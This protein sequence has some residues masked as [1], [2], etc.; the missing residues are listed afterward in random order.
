MSGFHF[1]VCLTSTETYV[2]S[3]IRN[4]MLLKILLESGATFNWLSKDPKQQ[5][6]IRAK[7]FTIDSW[8][9]LKAN[10]M[11]C[12]K[13]RVT[14]SLLFLVVNLIC[15]GSA[16]F[17]DQSGRSWVKGKESWIAFD[18]QLKFGCRLYSFVLSFSKL[19]L[20]P[21][22]WSSHWFTKR[23]ARGNWNRNLW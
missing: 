2:N 9:K 7:V 20:D 23:L 6:P 10:H 19:E 1:F 21:R 5:Q 3:H 15:W 14:I 16:S 17:L 8:W 11:K 22:K 12:R 13:T 4:E 18:S